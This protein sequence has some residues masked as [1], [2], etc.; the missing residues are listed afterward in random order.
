M[1]VAVS[2]DEQ[3]AWI[4]D[5]VLADDDSRISVW[6]RESSGAWVNEAQFGC[7]GSGQCP[8]ILPFGVAAA[9]DGQTIW[10]ADTGNR[11]ISVWGLSGCP[12]A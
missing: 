3:T 5:T 12:P 1:R 7:D 8:F 6:K 4:I 11:R 2:A 9:S 10:V